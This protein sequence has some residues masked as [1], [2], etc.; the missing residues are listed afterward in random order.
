MKYLAF[1]ALILSA[2]GGEIKQLHDQAGQGWPTGKYVPRD[3][4]TLG[5]NM[6]PSYGGANTWGCCKWNGNACT[7][8]PT[9]STNLCHTPC[10]DHTTEAGCNT[11]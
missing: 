5:P 8:A 7:K 6:G 11:W 2:N 10:S 4:T 1:I 9:Y 3:N